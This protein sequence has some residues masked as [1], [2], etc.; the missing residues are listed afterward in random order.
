ML[1]SLKNKNT[2]EIVT[3]VG[4]SWGCRGHDYT[5]IGK[6]GKKVV[7]SE[8]ALKKNYTPVEYPD[9]DKVLKVVAGIF[10]TSQTI[11]RAIF[12]IMRRL[13]PGGYFNVGDLVFMDAPYITREADNISS[14]GWNSYT[15][16]TTFIIRDIIPDFSK[17][18]GYD[19]VVIAPWRGPKVAL[20]KY[21][22]INDIA[23]PIS[24]DRYTE[25]DAYFYL[26]RFDQPY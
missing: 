11:R 1:Y 12:P 10:D 19:S 23:I 13:H 22:G 8:K 24:T 3:I 16:T 2:G 14:L 18:D 17:G 4:E 20:D 25:Q 7:L 21:D 5:V 9:L 15:G 26:H 6:T